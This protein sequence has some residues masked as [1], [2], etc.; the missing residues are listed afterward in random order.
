MLPPPNVVGS[1]RIKFGYY[2]PPPTESGRLAEMRE[3][4]ATTVVPP[5]PPLNRVGF[6]RSRKR[7]K[8]FNKLNFITWQEIQQAQLGSS[9]V[10]FWT[11][12]CVLKYSQ[13]ELVQYRVKYLLD[14]RWQ[15]QYVWA[16]VSD[17]GLVGP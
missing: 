16:L 4:Y 17:S 14:G 10:M 13:N 11:I 7:L 15:H 1:R 5:P 12:P 2:S 9:V 8:K 6:W 3:N